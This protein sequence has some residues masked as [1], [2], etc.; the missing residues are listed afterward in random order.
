MVVGSLMIIL[1]LWL[2]LT[3]VM[4]SYDY[5]DLRAPPIHLFLHLHLHSAS[6]A[7]PIER[8][9]SPICGSPHLTITHCA[10]V[11]CADESPFI[12]LLLHGSVTHAAAYLSDPPSVNCLSTHSLRSSP[13]SSLI[14]W[15]LRCMLWVDVMATVCLLVVANRPCRG[16]V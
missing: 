6:R 1:Y 7:L 14:H 2:S 5:D 9:S 8:S 3:L 12:V 13:P 15:G 4:N 10:S 11:C 16:P